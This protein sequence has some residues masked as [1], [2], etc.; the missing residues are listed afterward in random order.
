[1]SKN[2]LKALTKGGGRFKH[3][4]VGQAWN[5]WQGR[6]QELAEQKRKVKKVLQRMTGNASRGMFRLWRRVTRAE[7]N[8][9]PNADSQER[10]AQRNTPAAQHVGSPSRAVPART[11]SQRMGNVSGAEVQ[12]QS[13][14]E[15]RHRQVVGQGASGTRMQTPQHVNQREGLGEVRRFQAASSSEQA[16]PP[17]LPLNSARS[18]K[19]SHSTNPASPRES[20]RQNS[21]RPPMISFRNADSSKPRPSTSTSSYIS[22]PRN[23][24]QSG[25]SSA[26]TALDN[27]GKA[28]SPRSLMSPRSMTSAR[29]MVSPR[30]SKMMHAQGGVMDL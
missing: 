29:P 26:Q 12:A 4:R 9:G 13:Q 21:L 22:R 28:V 27:V 24:S 17:V 25:P 16:L 20:E 6:V 11:S 23:S 14:P 19:M 1:M 10:P 7:K 18:S 5:T 2:Q 15:D 30:S 8:V 3:Y